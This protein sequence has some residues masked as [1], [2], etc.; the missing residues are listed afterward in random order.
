MQCGSVRASVWKNTAEVKG[1]EREFYNVTFQRSYLDGKEWKNVD[2]YGVGDLPKI[3]AIADV[4][5]KQ[6]GMT[7]GE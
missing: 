2:S 4:L 1:E 6:Y 3:A 5:Y 7:I